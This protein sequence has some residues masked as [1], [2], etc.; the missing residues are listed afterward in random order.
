MSPWR[1]PPPEP[2]RDGV[3]VAAGLFLVVLVLLAA[4]VLAGGCAVPIQC[5]IG[6]F[7]ASSSTAEETTGNGKVSVPAAS[8]A[9][10]F[11]TEARAA[12][13]C[14]RTCQAGQLLKASQDGRGVVS[15]ECSPPGPAKLPGQGP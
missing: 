15:V 3:H 4:L 12:T 11:T 8:G 6:T 10:G 14:V 1:R 9:A 7:P 13:K 2:T 5:P